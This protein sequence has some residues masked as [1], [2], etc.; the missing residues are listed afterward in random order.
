MNI[1][2]VHDNIP[3]SKYGDAIQR[4][5]VGRQAKIKI[6]ITGNGDEERQTTTTTN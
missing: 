4:Q 1:H 5:Y 2:V 6:K 3:S